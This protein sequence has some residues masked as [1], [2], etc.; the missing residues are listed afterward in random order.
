[1]VGKESRTAPGVKGVTRMSSPNEPAAVPAL[2]LKAQYRSI[3]DE[4]DRAV[5]SVVESQ[6]FIL[7]PEVAALEQEVADYW[8]AAHGVGCASGSDA[9]LLPLLALGVGPG[10]EVIPSPYSFFA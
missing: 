5:R 10:D 3:R 9:L 1:M 6:H 2:D 7:G 4:I 8:G